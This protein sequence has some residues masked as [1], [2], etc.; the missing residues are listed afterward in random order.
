MAENRPLS[1]PPPAGGPGAGG[2]PAGGPPPAG[3]PGGGPAP[4]GGPGGGPPPP[5][6]LPPVA[7]GYNATV[8]RVNLTDKKISIEQ[9]S[10]D[11]CRKYIGGAG[12]V[13]YYLWKEVKPGCDPLGPDNKLVFANGPASGYTLPGAARYCV[14]CKSPLGNSIAKAE[15]GGFWMAELKRAGYDVIIVEGKS[16]KPVY[17]WVKDGHAEI[18]DAGKVWGT[19]VKETQEAIRKELGDEKVQL[20]MIGQGG[21]N[22][23]RYACIMTGC[24]DAA[25]RGGMGAVMGSKNLKAIAVKGSYLPRVMDEAK[26]TELRKAMS[27]PHPMS[28]GGTGGPGIAMME[29]SGN[30]PVNNFRDGLFPQ[31]KDITTGP[32]KETGIL[33]KMEGC[34]ACPVRCKKVVEFTE[35]YV[36]DGEYGGPEY[37]T[38]ASLGSDVGLND[39]RALCKANERCNAYSLDTISAGSTIA[40]AMECYEK[41]LITKKDTDGLELTWGNAEAVIKAVELIA[42]REGFGDLM[43]EGTARMA[44]KIGKGSEEFAMHT[45]GLE[46][47]M[48]EPRLNKALAIG[49]LVNPHGADH[50][51]SFGGG[52]SPM[53]L[54]ALHALGIFRAT[55]DNYSPYRMSIYKMTH[56]LGMIKDCMLMCS[57]VPCSTDRQV[58]ILKA[59]TGWNTGPVELMRAGQRILTIM[60]LFNIDQ[61][62]TDADD[63]LPERWYQPKANGALSKTARTKQEMDDARKYYYYY[64]GW[65]EKG[66]PRPE[67]L[68][69]LQ[70]D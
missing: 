14:G 2:P 60:R 23:V 7:G 69:E 36:H 32:M 34:F 66:V 53:G 13:A 59:I 57:Y 56:S 5:P 42:K 18:R 63:I 41:G 31:I 22:M 19:E 3:R 30:L 27:G 51:S 67:T 58:E 8:L 70:I 6:Q 62:F 47:G 17:L 65:D 43:A 54:D 24:H 21:E 46:P 20:A 1:G 64:M 39:L 4:A 49:Y 38:I 16:P 29:Q 28:D 12:F 48:H 9:L 50:C 52:T 35:P 25:G 45:K 37:E 44:K 61:G 68:A 55:E 10:Y 26:I 40:F 11:F 15:S 33:K